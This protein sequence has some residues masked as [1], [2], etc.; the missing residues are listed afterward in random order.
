MA[1]DLR[2]ALLGP[3]EI[4]VD[5][6]VVPVPG[7]TL[8]AVV[9]R[10]ALSPG[11]TVPVG[12]LVDLLWPEGPPQG[13]GSNLQTYVSRIRRLVGR[14]RV[15]LEAGGY[16]LRVAPEDVDVGLASRWARRA[17]ESPPAAAAS[18]LAEALGL[19]RGEPLGD[20]ADR[21]AFAPDVARLVE[22]RAH[23][24]ADWL[25][26]RLSLEPVVDVLPELEHAA[27]THPLRERMQLLLMRGLHRDG[28]TADALAVADAYRRALADASGL[29][30]GPE[31]TELAQRLR[32]EDGGAPRGRLPAAPVVRRRHAPPDRFVGRAT[33]LERLAEAVASPGLVTI[34]G[35]GG[36][37][38]T[39]LLREFLDRRPD[40][41][42]TVLVALGEVLASGDVATAVAAGLGLQAAPAGAAAAVAE[43][44]GAQPLVLG[45][46][47][48]EHVRAAA[49]RLAVLLL[50]S[51]P[52][53]RLVATSRQRLGVPGE[54]VLRL[55]PLAPPEQ[56]ELFV[57]RATRL[58]GD[59]DA[60]A[61]TVEAVCALVDGLP[62]GVELAA[63]REAVFGV[64]GLRE[65][66]AGGLAVL[67]PTAG[68]DRS[69][70]L[71]A[72]VEWSYRLL[73]PDA[74]ALF[75]RVVVCRGGFGPDA[76]TFLAPHGNAEGALAELVE[77]SMVVADHTADPPRFRVLETMRRAGL[78]HLDPTR[79][80]GAVEA[81][82]QWMQAHVDTV[83]ARQDER[84]PDAASLLRRE[85][86]NLAEA[87]ARAVE[88]E[89]WDVAGRL[90]VPLAVAVSDDPH[91]DL[92][93]Q[94][95]RLDGAPAAAADDDADA[96]AA[97]CAV[98]AGGAAWL[99]GDTARGEQ[100][101]TSA[102]QRLPHDHPD[103][104]AGWWFRSM[105][106][107]YTG[108]AA[109]VESDVHELLAH[110]GAPDWVRATAI[111]NAALIRLFTGD[112]TTAEA[113]LQA[114]TGLLAE[115]GEVDGFVAYTRGELAAET[116]PDAALGWFELAHHRND[117]RGDT[118]NRE[119][120]GVGRAA[121]LLRLGRL[122]EAGE[123]L[124]E[125]LGSLRR[126]G[127]W[128]QVWTTL[129]LAAEL[130]VELD[131]PGRAAA[132]LAAADRDPL[133]PAI[134]GAHRER[135]DRL[136]RR[137][138]ASTD[139]PVPPPPAG[140]AE[141]VALAVSALAVRRSGGQPTAGGEQV[142]SK[143]RAAPSRT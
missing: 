107:M 48:C 121:V 54:R 100:L 110:P 141:A 51:C 92:L 4:R 9:A 42:A 63:G 25:E 33:E 114:H 96:G 103:R 118:F 140:R 72:T 87:L 49:G 81:H 1:E 131:D 128:P 35:P 84:S 117:E 137:I 104:W 82:T 116:D 85:R 90:A 80:E 53:V 76:L 97:R 26:L 23:L 56:V 32:T 21:L 94:L 101:L 43:V 88:Q 15:V 66:L 34:T 44:I 2:V 3:V 16:R 67:E 20:V 135:D 124:R 6:R 13:A 40:A 30:P 55:A 125:L 68:G 108:D 78:G 7:A 31:M 37:G 27:R 71:G 132:L 29:D 59:F 99:R 143:E 134:L 12:E 136:R 122:A 126:L 28:R 70:A 62:L 38:K 60:A 18:L 86:A 127:M 11:R 119:V 112:R 57:D 138:A 5:G 91:L 52:Q 89:R 130:L 109:A 19:W 65:R 115:V 79:R 83:R 106:R 45:L 129:R 102:L 22:W 120:A 123:A 14:D 77:A 46:D 50:A 73:G 17:R 74:R 105:S 47:N 36:I 64:T 41:E 39:R 98:A 93:E 10:L 61:P 8:R 95:A 133:A 113:W 69:T 139:G 111:C 24:L 75:D 142:P 58:R